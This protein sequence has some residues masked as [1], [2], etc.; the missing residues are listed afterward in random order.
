[1]NLNHNMAFN[2]ILNGRKPTKQS[3]KWPHTNVEDL[4]YEDSFLIFL[5][6]RG[7]VSPLAF[8]WLD[9][10]SWQIGARANVVKIPFLADWGMMFM[11]R[12]TKE[13]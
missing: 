8:Y 10:E 12:E 13:S 2:D 4:S 5:K 11:G 6:S 9:K 7:T 1:M 3:C